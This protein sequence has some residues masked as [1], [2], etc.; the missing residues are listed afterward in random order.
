[1]LTWGEGLL[2]LV[3]LLRVEDTEG[4]QVLGAAHLELHNIFAPLDFHRAS[5]LPYS[6]KEEVLDLMDLL[7]LKQQAVV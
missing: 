5:I 1:M 4:V 6:S 2:Q 3:S 7:R